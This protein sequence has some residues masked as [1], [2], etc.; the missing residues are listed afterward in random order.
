MSITANG[1]PPAA[2][3]P[4]TRKC[5]QPLADCSC[6]ASPGATA[7]AANAVGLRKTASG[8][9]TD[10]RSGAVPSAAGRGISPGVTLATFSASMPT[11]RRAL[12]GLSAGWAESRR[13]W[14]LMSS[15]GLTS[16]TASSSANRA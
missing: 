2:T 12:R 11:I 9:R 16:A 3:V 4:A 14:L 7:S 13:A 5:C 10:R 8:A 6:S 1:A 15:T